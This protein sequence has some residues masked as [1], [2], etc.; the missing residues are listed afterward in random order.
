MLY[1]LTKLLITCI[2]IVA[3][4]EAAKRSSLLGAILASI[5]LVSVLAMV[6]LYIDT[7]DPE[8]IAALANGIF[9]LVIPSL[10]FFIA[11]PLLLRNG[12]NFFP[13]LF[14]SI[15][16]TAG[17]YALMVRILLRFGIQL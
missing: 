8:K 5:P 15:G 10:V 17:A 16:L 13:G 2:L 11:L 1:Y 6:W 9:W 12:V 3:I 14:I 4:S 7:K